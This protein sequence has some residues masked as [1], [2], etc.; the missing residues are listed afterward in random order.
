MKID[1]TCPIDVLRTRVITDEQGGRRA[2][3]EVQNLTEHPV[4]RIEM[5]ITWRDADGYVIRNDMIKFSPIRIVA[6][7]RAQLNVIG[8]RF[9]ARSVQASPHSVAFG[10]YSEGWDEDPE[11]AIEYELK[12]EPPGPG[13][14]RLCDLV[15]PD[16]VCYPEKRGEYWLCACGRLNENDVTECPRCA[17]GKERLFTILGRSASDSGQRYI[18]ASVARSP[19]RQERYNGRLDYVQRESDQSRRI[20]RGETRRRLAV[21]LLILAL[22]TSVALVCILLF[23]MPNFDIGG[24]LR[25]RGLLS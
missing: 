9:P 25:E 8:G 3:L 12:P 13:L 18:D 17:R 4:R 22:L 2:L 14:E 6:R 1:L 10:D 19:D 11:R 23:G 15:G 20:R 16:A 24:F 21:A 5:G 7:G